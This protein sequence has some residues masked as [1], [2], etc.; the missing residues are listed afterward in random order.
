MRIE[1]AA[2]SPAPGQFRLVATATSSPGVTNTDSRNATVI[3]RQ[4]VAENPNDADDDDDGLSDFDEGTV[5]PLPNGFPTDDP[6]YKPNPE[7]WTNGDI[8]I[9]DAYGQSHPLMPDSDGDGLPDGL[10]VG[11]RTGSIAT[12]T[13]T[14]TNA[15]GKPNFICA[16]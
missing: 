12:N 3:Y 8:H 13:A 16:A 7:Q 15:D 14:D 11:W 10:E 5:T 6:R 2:S 9:H 1:R 4:L